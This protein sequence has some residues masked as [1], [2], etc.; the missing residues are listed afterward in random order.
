MLTIKKLKKGVYNH[1]DSNNENNFV[2]YKYRYCDRYTVSINTLNRKQNYT[3]YIYTTTNT[4]YDM[5]FMINVFEE[6]TREFKW[7]SF[8]KYHDYSFILQKSNCYKLAEEFL[9]YYREESDSNIFSQIIQETF[10]EYMLKHFDKKLLK[11]RIT[12]MRGL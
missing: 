12:V 8:S 4:N 6:N 9:T 1:I 3:V 7:T 2:N 5:L 10:P 11:Y